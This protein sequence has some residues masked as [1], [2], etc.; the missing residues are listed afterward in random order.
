[1]VDN[2]YKSELV[3]LGVPDKFINHGTQQQLYTECYFDVGAIKES[4]HKLIS[5]KS[6]V[7]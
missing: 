3:R 5:R 1:M 6:Q 2:N 7:V 4:V